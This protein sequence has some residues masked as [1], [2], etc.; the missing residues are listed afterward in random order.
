MD[1]V[2]RLRDDKLMVMGVGTAAEFPALVEQREPGVRVRDQ[3]LERRLRAERPLVVLQAQGAGAG[4]VFTGAH[5]DYHK[6]S[7]TLRTRSTPA[8]C[9]R[10][11]PLRPRRWSTRSTLGR[12]SPTSRPRPTAP[13]AGSPAAAGTAP[14]SAPFPDYMK[15]EGGVLLSGV[16]T[17][18]PRRQ[19]RDSRRRRDRQVRRRCGWTTSTTTPSRCAR[20]SRGSRCA[21][22]VQR[23]GRIVDL[24]AAAGEAQVTRAAL[25]AR[26]RAC[27]AVADGPA[28]ARRPRPRRAAPI[29]AAAGHPRSPM[30]G[31]AVGR[32]A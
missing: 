15:T 30:P 23:G 1:M 11:A 29:T 25:V 3:D 14:T 24:I 17:R 6:P 22:R 9:A 4:T 19:R 21:S 20:G 12:A 8:G 13:W 18:Q 16:R 26:H 32:T 5:A 27:V 7:D 10:V 28:R 31:A 2:G